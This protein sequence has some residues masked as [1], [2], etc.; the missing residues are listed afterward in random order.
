MPAGMQASA[1][2]WAV[3]FLAA[4]AVLMPAQFL[5]KY[6]FLRQFFPARVE[7]TLWSD[8]MLYILM[9]AGAVGFVAVILWDTL[10]PARRDAFVLTPLPVRLPVQM[11][12]RLGGVL[13]FYLVFAAALNVVPAVAFPLTAMPS[14]LSM[15][16]AMAGHLV[17]T[18]SADAFVFFSV[19]ALEGLVILA[20][21]R[22]LAARLAAIVQAG[23]VLIL[24]LTLMFMAPIREYT[25]HAVAAG[26]PNAPGLI[27]PLAW[28]LGLYEFIAGSPRGVMGT[29]AL[30]GVIA[31]VVPTVATFAIYG[32]GYQRLLARAVETTQRSTRS[33]LSRAGARVVRTLFIRR[34]EQQAIA[35]LTLRAIARSGRHSMMMSLYIGGG[36]ALILT[37]LISDIARLGPQVLRD[38]MTAWTLRR[39]TPPLAPLMVPLMLSAPLG[40]GVRMLMTIPADMNARWILQTSALTPR[41]VDGAVHK[42]M[43]LLVLLPVLVVAPLSAGILWGS[44]MALA[45]AAFCGALT[46]V[47]CELLL[48]GFRGVPLARPYVP[49]KARLHMLWA[50]YLFGFLTYTY[51]MAGVERALLETGGL[52][53]AL[54][55]AAVFVAIAAGLWLVRKLKIRELAD[56]PYEADIPNDEQFRGFNLSEVYTAQAVAGRL[57]DDIDDRRHRPAGDRVGGIVIAPENGTR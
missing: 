13:S 16:R 30:R 33:F 5:V 36:L 47:L 6:T 41:G 38:P 37:T 32:F 21:G 53:Y 12:G 20:F 39:V 19:T 54:R 29:L 56:V 10:F 44:R 18:V 35:S 3:A 14:F 22:R 1:I 55:A 48:L 8:R 51:S 24:L 40:V 45:H 25:V 28:F 27:A 15:P 34:P 49:G 31:A 52:T 11:L 42:T 23:A 50:A 17:A 4:P 26:D 9:S 57:E 2:I 43:L 7:A 46:L